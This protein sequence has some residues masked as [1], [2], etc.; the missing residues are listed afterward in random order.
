MWNSWLTENWHRKSKY[1]EQTC[2]SVTLPTTNPKLPDLGSN[3]GCPGGKPVSTHLSYST[4][5]C[6]KNQMKKSNSLHCLIVG[7]IIYDNMNMTLIA[8]LWLLGISVYGN[9]VKTI[10]PVNKKCNSPFNITM[11]KFCVMLCTIT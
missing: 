6:T 10:K 2:P 9:Y 1:L 7:V 4:A 5:W 3:L 8:C 11:E